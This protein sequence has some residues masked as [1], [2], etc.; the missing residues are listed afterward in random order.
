MSMNKTWRFFFQIIY[1]GAG[2]ATSFWKRGSFRSGSNIGSSRS[3]AGVSG[4]LDS[5]C[6][7][8]YGIESSFC[9]A[10]MARSGSP[11]LRRH[12]GEDLDRNGT[13]HRV[14]LDRDH[15]HGPFRQSQRGGFVT[16]AHIGQREIAN[17]ADN[18][19]A[20]L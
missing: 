12:P 8:A 9:K 2:E 10:A 18:F 3:S 19:P 6:A 20:V 17:E 11:Y 1:F 14:F 5:Q 4:T 13:I 7:F 15:G 16:E